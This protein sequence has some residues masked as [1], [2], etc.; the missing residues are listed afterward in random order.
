MTT[1]ISTPYSSTAANEAIPLWRGPLHL[2]VGTARMRGRGSLALRLSPEPVISWDQE[3]DTIIGAV[4]NASNGRLI[5]WGLG[6]DAEYQQTGWLQ[7]SGP[8]VVNIGAASQGF[9][10]KGIDIGTRQR[11][12]GLVFHVA[13]FP[14]YVGDPLSLGGAMWAGRL[15]FGWDGWEVALDQAQNEGELRAQLRSTFGHALTHVGR[16]R[17]TDGTPFTVGAGLRQIEGL[18]YLLGFV[19]GG[20]CGPALLS[21]RDSSD[22]AVWQRWSV[23]LVD[24]AKPRPSIFIDKDPRLLDRLAPGFMRRANGRAWSDSYRLAVALY[25][26]ANRGVPIEIGITLAQSALEVLA[27]STYVRSGRVS[28]SE[29][30]RGW[31]AARRIRELLRKAKIPTGVPAS[32]ALLTGLPG[33]SAPMDGPETVAYV[34]NGIVHPPRNRALRRLSSPELIATWRLMLWY[35]ELVILSLA[36]YSGD[37]RSRVDDQVSPV[38]WS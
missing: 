31:P 29:F 3:S 16:L 7:G 20:W 24:S 18:R 27:W 10:P 32:M 9:L 35:A 34:R 11:I 22:R 23:M 15:E 19:R 36:G 4:L 14:A 2:V 28:P 13:N 30:K 38:P 26:A 8:R 12:V 37:V 17:R 6:H 1:P 21:G 5:P 25:V 33:V